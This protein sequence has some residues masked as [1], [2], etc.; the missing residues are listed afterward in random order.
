MYAR[1][2]LPYNAI[3]ADE[4]PY[5][6]SLGT[7]VAEA[8]SVVPPPPS[9]ATNSDNSYLLGFVSGLC[10]GIADTICNYPPYGLHLRLQAGQVINP[11]R[12]PAIYT[13]GELF[14]GV[15]PYSVIIPITCIADGVQ[16]SLV[17]RFRW[18][19]FLATFVSGMTAAA[20]VSAPTSNIIIYQ[21]THSLTAPIA[22]R[23]FYTRYGLYGFTNG[24]SL[25]LIREGLYSSSVFWAKPT[26]QKQHQFLQNGLLCSIIVGIFATLL[27]QPFDTLATFKLRQQV[28]VSPYRAFQAMYK[29]AGGGWKGVR[30]FYLGTWLRGY[31]VVAGIYVMSTVSEYVKRA[32][33]LIQ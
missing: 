24:M 8:K 30:R 4:N 12:N 14:R 22:T 10:G 19:E 6:R 1:F 2:K 31:A 16:L 7:V 25:Y 33:H 11:F 21:Q 20:S 29:Q 32:F 26:L 15:L 3:A 23:A 28:R 17:R 9:A 18:H 13:P 27:S 5:A